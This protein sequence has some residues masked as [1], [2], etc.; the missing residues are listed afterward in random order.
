[1]SLLL[2]KT[3]NY[4]RKNLIFNG[5]D[6][7]AWSKKKVTPFYFY[8]LGILRQ[9]AK[10]LLIAA[11]K[12]GPDNTHFCY[13]VKANHHPRILQE[14]SKLGFG[15]DVVSAGELERATKNKM[16]AKG[17]VF[18]GVA[19]TQ[20]EIVYAIKQRILSLNVES[21]AELK[22]IQK[23]AK[24]LKINTAVT[25][26][27]NPD[28]KVDTH[29]H[30]STGHKDHKFGLL[31]D[32]IWSG[33][34]M[35]KN[36][37]YVEFKGLSIHVGSQLLQLKDFTRSFEKVAKLAATLPV[38]QTMLD[39]GGG[40][41]I[42]Y[43]QSE[44]KNILT[45]KLYMKSLKNILE[46]H[47]FLP[48]PE[49]RGMKIVFEPGRFVVARCGVLVT[50]VVRIKKSRGHIFVIVDAGMNELMRPAL[51]DAYHEIMPL[52]RRSGVESVHIVGPICETSDCFAKFRKMS[53]L[54]ENDF[55]LVA[56][57]GAYG[58]SMAN[59]Y[60]LRTPAVEY[61]Y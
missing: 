20:D 37:P 26:R 38:K 4:K 32:D 60:N 16:S 46:K 56:D 28:V 44:S 9:Q 54:Q 6:L 41:G 1:M 53:K 27:F 25:L 55:V 59:N 48:R 39:V 58:K 33:L 45:L 35:L 49:L 14:L 47:L 57:T 3:F 18:S 42:D 61:F 12:Y 40:L 7:A 23:L 2:K 19:K 17:C 52:V 11:K 30:I 29:R 43:H 8:H 15:A 5:I 10:A 36:D 50:K 22:M 51:Y 34:E 24:K 13:A 21:L 31:E